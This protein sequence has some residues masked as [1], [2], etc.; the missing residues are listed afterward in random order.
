MTDVHMF[1]SKFVFLSFFNPHIMSVL[2]VT[3]SIF[4]TVKGAKGCDLASN[5]R[6][7]LLSPESA[8]RLAERI[9]I[10]SWIIN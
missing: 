8:Q 7:L 1:L 2:L 10:R 3:V 4:F 5:T 9:C 6:N